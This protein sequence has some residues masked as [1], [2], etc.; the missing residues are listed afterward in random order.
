MHKTDEARIAVIGGGTGL[1]VLL[2][3]IKKYKNDISA[4]VTVADDGGNSGTL[5]ED[6]GML[7]PGDVRS[8]IL[9][10]ADEENAMQEILR[11]RFKEGRLAGQNIGNMMIAALNDVYGSFEEAVSRLSDILKIQGRVI[12]VTE[13]EL[14]LCAELANGNIVVGESQLAKAAIG[15]GYPIKRVFMIPDDSVISG[16]AREAVERADLI[17]IGPGSLYTSIIPN[18]LSRGLTEAL[19]ASAGRK[20][21]ICNVMTQPGE[22]DG[23]GVREHVRALENYIGSGI[24]EYVI[25]NNRILNDD[26]LSPYVKDGAIQVIPRTEDRKYLSSKGITLL[27]GDFIETKK[28]YIRHDSARIAEALSFITIKKENEGRRENGKTGNNC[29]YLRG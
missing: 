27:D 8:C 7:P 14:R 28:G 11:Y 12:P 23:F 3:G 22:T 26:T 21:Y 20:A 15:E 5:R 18:F 19:A 16:Q 24:L 10:L 6:L 2:R 1:S 13:S 29:G 4:I 25:A 17:L 9:A